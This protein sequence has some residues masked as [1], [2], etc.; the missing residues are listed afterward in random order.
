VNVRCPESHRRSNDRELLIATVS[1]WPTPESRSQSENHSLD[2]VPYF[3]TRRVP[4][5]ELMCARHDRTPKRSFCPRHLSMGSVAS[6]HPAGSAGVRRPDAGLSPHENGQAL[7]S[8]KRSRSKVGNVYAFCQPKPGR[9]HA[10]RPPV[11][12]VSRN[13]YGHKIAGGRGTPP[14]NVAGPSRP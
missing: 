3:R 6:R 8:P 10:F 1:S 4:V 11:S 5:S 13:S 2:R 12:E 9:T 14:V 7:T